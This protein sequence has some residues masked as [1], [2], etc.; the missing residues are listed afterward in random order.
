[1]PLV[2]MNACTKDLIIDVKAPYIIQ[3][4]EVTFITRNYL[5][6]LCVKLLR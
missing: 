5:Y 4:I 2:I 1:M 6:I 3:G